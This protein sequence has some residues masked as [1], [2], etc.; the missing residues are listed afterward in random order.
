MWNMMMGTNLVIKSL[1]CKQ[2]DGLQQPFC[3][4]EYMYV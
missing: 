2:N 1:G 3:K 4:P